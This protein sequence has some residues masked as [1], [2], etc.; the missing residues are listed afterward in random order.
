MTPI[1]FGTDG[2][3]AV[4]GRD[5]TYEN[6]RKVIQAWCDIQSRKEGRGKWEVVL[7][8]DRRFSSDLFAQEVAGVLAANGFHTLISE[9][10]C[11][12]PCVSWMTKEEKALAG[13]VITASHNP[14]QWNGVKFKESYGG[15]ASPEYCQKIEEQIVK[16]DAAKRSALFMSFEEAE[17]KV[18]VKTF[19]PQ[20]YIEHLRTLVDIPRIKKSKLKIA[21][22][23]LYGAGSGFVAEVLGEEITE[24][25]CDANPGFGG[26]NPEPIEKNLKALLKTIVTQKCDIGLAT[27]G[28]ADR[29]GAV[30]E[31][32]NFIDSHKIF[33]LLLRHLVFEQ[34]RRGDVVTTVSTTQMVAR[35][36]KKFNLPLHETPIGF[37][38]ICQKFLESKTPLMGGE[39]SGG[40]GMAHHVY[41]RDGIL[42]GLL[43]LDILARH[44]KPISQII[45]DLQKEVGP[46]HFV[47][48]DLHVPQEQITAIKQK[49]N[50]GPPQNLC[51]EKIVKNNFKDGFK[52]ILA[53]DSW[54]LIRPS[55]TEPLLR[56]YAE[57]PTLEKAQKMI[58]EAKRMIEM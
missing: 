13:I 11:P 8:Y 15:S 38:Y 32:G 28:D 19:S 31:K 47:R 9:T 12:T 34:N 50:Q 21:V 1:K 25:R 26:V 7:G 52:F 56:V 29:I 44:Q 23:S 43:L 3:R 6:V 41:E 55:G 35:L 36:C 49:M 2:W 53:D 30:D 45:E 17:K 46:L 5:Y 51:G 10:Y 54:L 42:S 14:Y 33:S 37:K 18:W 58:E 16:N 4:I 39:E 40:L 48:E 22:D 24:I 20:R 27:D 57:A